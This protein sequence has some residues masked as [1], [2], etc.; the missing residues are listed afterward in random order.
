MRLLIATVLIAGLSGQVWAQTCP[1]PAGWTKPERHLA[2]KTPE[3]KFGLKPGGTI[4][5]GLLSQG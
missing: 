5:I 3:M 4:Q 2:A 1:E